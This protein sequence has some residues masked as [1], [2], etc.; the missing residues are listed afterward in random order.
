[1]YVNFVGIEGQA[2]VRDAYSQN[3]ER[4]ASIKTQYDPTNFFHKNHNIAPKRK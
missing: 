4:L 3:W 1:V 2:R